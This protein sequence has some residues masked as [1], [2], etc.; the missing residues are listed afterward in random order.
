MWLIESILA[1]L[2]LSNIEGDAAN[3]LYGLMSL[4]PLTSD[5]CSR[6]SLIQSGYA[7]LTF[8]RLLAPLAGYFQLQVD[9]FQALSVALV[10]RSSC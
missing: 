10:S 6:G 5:M 9:P 1:R 4:T 2:G 8:S 3:A 7:A